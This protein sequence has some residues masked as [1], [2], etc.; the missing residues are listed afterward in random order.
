[1]IYD[2]QIYLLSE[3][4]RRRYHTDDYPEM[5]SKAGRPYNCL[6]IDSHDDYFI[7]VP[8]RSSISHK[9]AYHFKKSKR[10]RESRSGLDYSKIVIIR[11]S[12]YLSSENAIIDNDEYNETIENMDKIVGEVLKYVDT[13]KLHVKGVMKIHEKDFVRAYKFSTLKYFHNE[14][15]LPVKKEEKFC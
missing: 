14:L 11:D 12:S 15:G 1:M 6:L 2:K 4:F 3:A 5:M 13:Y 10:S 9:N 8:Y 7:C